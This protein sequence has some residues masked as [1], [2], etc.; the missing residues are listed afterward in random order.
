[1]AMF[2]SGGQHPRELAGNV[3]WDAKLWVAFKNGKSMTNPDHLLKNPEK[4]CFYSVKYT[5]ITGIS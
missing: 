2:M 1:M 5:I 4:A 3:H